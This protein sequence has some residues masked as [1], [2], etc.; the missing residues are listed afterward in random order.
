M[1]FG[2]MKMLFRLQKYI[3]ALLFVSFLLGMLLGIALVTNTDFGWGMLTLLRSE[4]GSSRDIADGYSGPKM[5]DSSLMNKMKA[6]G[7][8]YKKGLGGLSPLEPLDQNANTLRN[9]IGN[10]QNKASRKGVSPVKRI[11]SVS[12]N[13]HIFYYPWYSNPKLDEK[14][15][16]WNHPYLPHW[17]KQETD[18]WPKGSH[19][20]PADLGSNYYPE[21]G[22]YSSTDPKVIKAH[23]EQIKGAN[24]GK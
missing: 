11:T 2:W 3:V 4:S 9:M 23:M 15:F 10:K 21:L 8:L 19:V 14:Y 24:I 13:V 12:N 6:K 7:S 16:H 22:P 1:A 18:K 5:G 20:P 17:D